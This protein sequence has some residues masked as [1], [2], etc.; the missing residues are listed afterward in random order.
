LFLVYVGTPWNDQAH[1]A[2]WPE[3]PKAV[4]LTWKLVNEGS[5][6]YTENI[7]AILEDARGWQRG[8]LDFEQVDVRESVDILIVMYNAQRDKPCGNKSG[9]IGCALGNALTSRG[10]VVF[11]PTGFANTEVMIAFVNHEVGHC[12]GFSHAYS[13]NDRIMRPSFTRDRFN[14]VDDG[15]FWPADDEIEALRR[16]LNALFNGGINNPAHSARD[17]SLQVS[18]NVDDALDAPDF[19]EDFFE[20]LS[21]RQA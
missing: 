1:V 8:E 5:F 9:L 4:V 10:C 21:F 3:D 13:S 18:G 2:E 20:C 15:P 17:F 14:N 7:H 6:D 16:R 12:V 11:L 19:L